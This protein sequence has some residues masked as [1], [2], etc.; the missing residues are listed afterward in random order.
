MA[1]WIE[2]FQVILFLSGTSRFGIGL[3]RT[4]HNLVAVMIG[5]SDADYR[6]YRN[7]PK[8][9]YEHVLLQFL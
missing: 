1:H 6:D 7:E 2:G 9:D 3:V 8:S 4:I 5:Y